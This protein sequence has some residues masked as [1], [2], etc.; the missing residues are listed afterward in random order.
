MQRAV[1]AGMRLALGPAAR[2]ALRFVTLR[3]PAPAKAGGGVLELSGVLGGSFSC[4]RSA[5]FSLSSA[6]TRPDSSAT[7]A[8]S[9]STRASNATISASFSGALSNVGSG[10]RVIGI[11]THIPPPLASKIYM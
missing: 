7:C 1:R 3:K 2:F 9:S 6:R 10:G 11:L 4:A 8:L 5:A